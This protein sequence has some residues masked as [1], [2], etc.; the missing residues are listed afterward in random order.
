M[1]VCFVFILHARLRVLTGH[2]AFPAPSIS[3]GRINAKLGRFSRR[4]IA[5]PHLSAV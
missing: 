2:P 3:Q 1:L 4:E 5:E